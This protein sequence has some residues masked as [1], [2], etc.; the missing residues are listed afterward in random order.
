MKQTTVILPTT[1]NRAPLVEL[2]VASVLSQTLTDLELFIVGDGV[3]ERSKDQIHSLTRLDERVRYFDHPK[4]ERRG[5]PYRHELLKH[6]ANGEIVCYICDRDLWLPDHLETL[7]AILQDFDLAFGFFVRPLKESDRVIYGNLAREYQFGPVAGDRLEHVTCKLSCVGHTLAMY[8]RLPYG[9]RTTPTPKPTDQ[10]MWR[11]FLAHRDCR[12]FV[13]PHPT[14]LY[15]KRG[16]H[17]GWPVERRLAELQRW[18]EI[19]QD[20]GP[21]WVRRE[22]MTGVFREV[23]GYQAEV[24]RLSDKLSESEKRERHK[25]SELREENELRPMELKQAHAALKQCSLTTRALENK[26]SE[27]QGANQALKDALKALEQELN[28]TRKEIEALYTS[29]SW[30]LTAPLRKALDLFT[31]GGEDG[32]GLVKR[33]IATTEQTAAHEANRRQRRDTG[34]AARVVRRDLC[35][36]PI[37]DGLQLEV[38]WKVLAIG[39]GPAVIFRAHGRQIMKYDCFGQ[40]KGHY[41]IA[42]NWGARIYFQEATALEQIY[43][44]SRELRRNAQRSLRLQGDERIKNT[45]VNR[46]SLAVAAEQAASKMTS[47]LA[48]VS[49]LEDI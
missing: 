29:K 17:P 24:A 12:A 19:V 21:D 16:G 31:R 41:H 23:V 42:P 8:Q 34:A 43:R 30:K 35:V 9:W 28:R 39:K 40:G 7:H 27:L 25:I 1:G 10:Y 49:E 14:V 11:Q 47:F 26:T 15:F 3:A 5:E 2:A 22:A 36:I 32:T 38:Y 48:D 4:H 33:G 6:E 46:K 13:T 20:Q 45:I 18:W 44:A 37:Q